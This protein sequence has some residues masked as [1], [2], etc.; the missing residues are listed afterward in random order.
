LWCQ[1]L[2]RG[3]RGAAPRPDY[4]ARA[5]CCSAA[6]GGTCVPGLGCHGHILA[7]PVLGHCVWG[8]GRAL[9]VREFGHSN[10]ENAN[11]SVQCQRVHAQAYARLLMMSVLVSCSPRRMQGLLHPSPSWAAAVM[12]APPAMGGGALLQLVTPASAATALASSP[13]WQALA[14]GTTVAED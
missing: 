7:V 10:D 2:R 1:Q 3:T 12:S 13:I 6:H 8:S 14:P 11:C 4:P 5:C 9:Q